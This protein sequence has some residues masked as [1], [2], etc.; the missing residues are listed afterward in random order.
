MTLNADL[1]I[2]ANPR[3]VKVEAF[4]EYLGKLDFKHKLVIAVRAVRAVRA[5]LNIMD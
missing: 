2:R 1:N 4:N 3:D 5:V